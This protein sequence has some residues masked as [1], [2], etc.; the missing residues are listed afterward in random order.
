MGEDG[1]DCDVFVGRELY[2]FGKDESLRHM[3]LLLDA[4]KV[5]FVKDADV[6]AVL[7]NQQQTCGKRHYDEPAFV[8]KVRELCDVH[9]VG[10]CG[11]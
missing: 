5:V 6:G 11:F 2:Q 3:L 7:V 9:Q 8:L 1:F 4:T 10:Q